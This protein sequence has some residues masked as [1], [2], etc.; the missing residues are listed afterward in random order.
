[1]KK[2][3]QKSTVIDLGKVSKVTRG[4]AVFDLDI[5]GGQQRYTAG[6]VAD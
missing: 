5:S 1:M 2:Q 6:I 3:A 4:Q